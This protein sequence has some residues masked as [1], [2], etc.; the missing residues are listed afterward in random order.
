MVS[1]QRSRTS[2]AI[3]LFDDFRNC[4]LGFASGNQCV[5]RSAMYNARVA[6]GMD[7]HASLRWRGI[8]RFE[9]KAGDTRFPQDAGAE[10]RGRAEGTTT[11]PYP[12]EA[13]VRGGLRCFQECK[14]QRRRL[15]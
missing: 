11:R 10:K 9:N 3:A 12:L 1:F 5:L 6:M 8:R 13:M 2:C 15:S 14:V 4:L 7:V